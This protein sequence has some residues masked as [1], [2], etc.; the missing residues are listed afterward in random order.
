LAIHYAYSHDSPELQT[1]FPSTQSTVP[2]G[3]QE[4]DIQGVVGRLQ[5]LP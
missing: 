5:M 1:H 4:L 2:R 3:S